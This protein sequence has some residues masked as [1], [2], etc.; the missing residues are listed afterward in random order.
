M[1]S[2]I[3]VAVGALAVAALLSVSP[4]AEAQ[5]PATPANAEAFL[6]TWALSMEGP[7]GPLDLELTL[8]AEGGAVV[9]DIGGGDLPMTKVTDI[10]EAAENLVLA[11][12]LD[13]QGMEIPAEVTLTP[14]G[15]DLT[16]NF[17]LAGGQFMMPGTGTKK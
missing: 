1:L 5:S 3:P 9:G 4:A 15:A 8:A 17:D 6:G 7:M 16:V 11:Y 12:V 10:S 14:N 2:R 13:V